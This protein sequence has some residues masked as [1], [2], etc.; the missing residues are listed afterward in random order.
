MKKIDGYVCVAFLAEVRPIPSCQLFG[1]AVARSMRRKGYEAITT[2]GLEPFDSVDEALAAAG[3]LGERDDIENV[4]V[5]RLQLELAESIG[6]N[7]S[8][9]FAGSRSLIIIVKEE[10][11][12]G[13]RLLG[14]T[15]KGAPQTC[16]ETCSELQ[17]N[18][19][20]TF[21]DSQSVRY[22]LSQVARLSQLPTRLATFT[23]ERVK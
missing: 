8:P 21:A 16:N 1:A 11:G 22:P 7:Q 3:R 18:G 2:N 17:A 14:P 12:G 4:W 5:G 15:V 19:L 9:L 6:E 20:K 10:Y 13:H 23:L